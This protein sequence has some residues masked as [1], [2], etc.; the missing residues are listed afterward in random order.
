MYQATTDIVIKT[1]NF[2][3]NI[4]LPNIL[5]NYE[6]AGAKFDEGKLSILFEKGNDHDE[7][8]NVT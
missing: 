8:G 5:R 7:K 4:P 3:R 2:K 6:V 1:G